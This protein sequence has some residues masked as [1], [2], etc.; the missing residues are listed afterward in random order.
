M[1]LPAR[2]FVSFSLLVVIANPLRAQTSPP[3]TS[4]QAVQRDPEALRLLS[5]S[6]QRMGGAN[7]SSIVDI[8]ARGQIFRP[9]NAAEPIG[10]FVGKVRGK[11]FSMEVTPNGQVTKYAVLNG[12]GSVMKN[13]EVRVLANYN[14][15]G[16]GL[17]ILPLFARWTEFGASDAAV[18]PPAATQVDGAPCFEIHIVL[19]SQNALNDHNKIV[20]LIDQTSGLVSSIKYSMTLGPHAQDK[21]PVENRFF[22]YQSFGQILV[23]I[24]ITRYVN[25]MASAVLKIGDLRSNNGLAD[26]DFRN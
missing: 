21:V 20:V 18:G 8:T 7:R 19:S 1:R 10:T 3:T 15:E 25:G 17:D 5:Q 14:T 9:G 23:P 12:S 13:G 2:P 26:S 24:R 16:L 22:E 11:D 4:P 6:Y